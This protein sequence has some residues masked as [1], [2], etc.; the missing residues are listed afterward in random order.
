LLTGEG[1][2]VGDSPAQTLRRQLEGERRPDDELHPLL[3]QLVRRA[4]ALDPAKR[5]ASM[6]DISRQLN[7]ISDG[8]R[9]G[10]GQATVVATEERVDLIDAQVITSETFRHPARG[11]GIKAEFGVPSEA[12]IHRAFFYE[13]GSRETPAHLFESL[14]SLWPGAEVSIFDGVRVES[15]KGDFISGDGRTLPVIEPHFMLPV[16]AVV[17]SQ[18][19]AAGDCPTRHFVD[20]RDRRPSTIHLVL[21]RL[22]HTLLDNLVAAHGRGSF[23]THFRDAVEGMKVE[24]VAAGLNDEQLTSTKDELRQSFE[25]LAAFVARQHNKPGTE[26]VEVTRYS[27]RYGLEGRVDLI[28]DAGPSVEIFELKSGKRQNPEHVAQLQCYSLLWGRSAKPVQARLLYSRVGLE[29]PV[30]PLLEGGDRRLLRTRNTLVSAHQRLAEGEFETAMPYHGQWESRCRDSPCRFRRKTCQ[31]QCAVLGL[32]PGSD[33]EAW[34]GVPADLVGAARRYYRHFVMLIERE[35]RAASQHQSRFTRL[36]GLERRVESGAAVGSLSINQWDAGLS[37]VELTGQHVDRITP[38]SDVIIHRGDPESTDILLGRVELSEAERLVVRSDGATSCKDWVKGGWIAEPISM[39][40]GHAEA[41]LGIFDLMRCRRLDMLRWLLDPEWSDNGPETAPP[42]EGTS[43]LI[44]ALN[45]EQQQATIEAIYRTGPVIIHGPPGTGKTTVIATAIREAV[46][47]GQR[48]LLV[49]GTNTA[50]DNALSKLHELDVDFLRLGSAAPDLGWAEK[51]SE[52]GLAWSAM[53]LDAVRRRLLEAPVVAGTA[54]RA[55]RS[56]AVDVMRQASGDN[57]PFD[58]VIVDE[59]TQLTEPLCLGA[60]LLGNRFVLVGDDRQLPPVISAADALSPVVSGISSTPM[61]R[62]LRGLEWTMFERLKG[63][64]HTVLLREQY[65]MAPAIQEISNTLYYEGQ[66]RAS[67]SA[68]SRR[69]EVD[70]EILH[71][72][73]PVAKRRLDPDRPV[74]WEHVIAAPDTER[75]SRAEAEQIVRT[76]AALFQPGLAPTEVLGQIGVISPFRAQCHL[77]RSALRNALGEESAGRVEV[78]TV[79][80][81]QGR[82]KEVVLL[83]LVVPTWSEFVMDQRRLNV[84]LTRARSKLIIFGPRQLQYRVET[85][86]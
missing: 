49:A 12:K 31:A 52:R 62:A 34:Q 39:R 33:A 83:S 23:D 45:A 38:G 35:Y 25:W 36:D 70:P 30:E 59:A 82:E 16:T 57:P 73:D 65:R 18:G 28:H 11:L 63:S 3:A 5:Y 81:F 55:V 85:A 7:R 75:S 67:A 44:K 40:L 32:E 6:A 2:F 46:S 42:S 41:H 68:A 48:V 64:V 56:S 76:I 22:V 14:E 8:M 29:K 37:A 54:H 69:L 47:A 61:P 71:T 24:A 60:V 27:G 21:G 26:T 53:P 84:A 1:P 17:R 79:E 9:S 72:L 77:I 19:V 66:L 50:V 15:A 43:A 58:L 13:T 51:H 10:T 78:D 4:T 86:A 74:V 80:R 20:I